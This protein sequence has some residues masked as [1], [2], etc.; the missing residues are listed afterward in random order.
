MRRCLRRLSG[1]IWPGHERPGL[2]DGEDSG[3][4]VLGLKTTNLMLKE[5]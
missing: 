3:G 1:N 4:I 5:K 2:F